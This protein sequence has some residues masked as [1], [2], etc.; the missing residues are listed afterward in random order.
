MET[1]GVRRL[2]ADEYLKRRYEIPADLPDLPLA[3]E[4]FVKAW[5]AASGRQTLDFLA[6]A[7]SLPV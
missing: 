7:F 1:T 5:R 6:E 4:P 2:S 3:D